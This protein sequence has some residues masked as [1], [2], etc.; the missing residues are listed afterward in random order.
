MFNCRYIFISVLFSLP[1]AAPE[2]SAVA[3]MLANIAA[4]IICLYNL[5]AKNNTTIMINILMASAF[6]KLSNAAVG[7]LT[8]RFAILLAKNAANITENPPIKAETPA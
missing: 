3:A 5:K 6:N 2:I 1:I 8:S 7:V 4:G